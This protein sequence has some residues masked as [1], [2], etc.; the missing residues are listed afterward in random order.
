MFFIVNQSNLDSG[1]TPILLSCRTSVLKYFVGAK[2]YQPRSMGYKENSNMIFGV[3]D[4]VVGKLTT[5][6]YKTIF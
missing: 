4:F 5:D 1:C 3:A 6:L 2:I